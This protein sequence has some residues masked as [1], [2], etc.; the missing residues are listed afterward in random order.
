[1]TPKKSIWLLVFLFTM[2]TSQF[3]SARIDEGATIKGKIAQ[4]KYKDFNIDLNELKTRLLEQ[5]VFA[6]PPLPA[7]WNEMKLPQRQEWMKNFRESD[8]GKAFIKQNQALAEKSEKFDIKIEEDG[9]FVVYDVPPGKYGLRGRVDKLLKQRSFAFEVFGQVE[10]L[11]EVDELVLEPIMVLVTPLLK[12][13][14]PSPSFKVATHDDSANLVPQ[15]FRG[16]FLF[17]NF[18]S[19]ESPPSLEFQPEVQELLTA[20]TQNQHEFELLSV[21]VDSERAKGV[22][23]IKT[24]RMRGRHGFTDGWEHTMLE[25]FGIRALPSHWLIGPDG[26]IVMTHS[27]FRHAFISGKPN[28]ATIVDDR[29]TG[30]DIPT[31]VGNDDDSG[32]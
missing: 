16:K 28:L 1:M 7:T 24:K 31:P 15:H 22:D 5:V 9:R 14:E 32:E 27:D 21:N 23:M 4:S 11:E 20:M 6:Q 18:W 29:I 26:K 19:T 12:A 30:K 3:A 25:A 10:V 13:G 17:L 2:T 8:E